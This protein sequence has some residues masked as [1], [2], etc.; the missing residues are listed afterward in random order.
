M[1]VAPILAKLVCIFE[2]GVVGNEGLLVL[3]LRV[4]LLLKVLAEV[5]GL[6]TLL[7]LVLELN[8]LLAHICFE[9]RREATLKAPLYI[10]LIVS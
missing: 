1:Q 9:L 8:S 6:C 10:F 7:Q 5:R 3:H 2:P 4:D